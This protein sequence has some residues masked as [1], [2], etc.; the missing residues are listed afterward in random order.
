MIEHVTKRGKR[1]R[2]VIRTDLT[3]DEAKALDPY[4]FKKCNGWFIRED[5]A[6]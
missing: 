4:T 6:K 3:Q 2:G 5:K 1:L